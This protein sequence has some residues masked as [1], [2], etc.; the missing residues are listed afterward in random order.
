[1]ERFSQT[2]IESRFKTTFD[3]YLDLLKNDKVT[4]AE[5]A[6]VTAGEL[7]ERILNRYVEQG[8]DKGKRKDFSLYLI[9][10]RLIDSYFKGKMP[11]K[12]DIKENKNFYKE[13]DSVLKIPSVMKRKLDSKDHP[14]KIL[15][16]TENKMKS[17]DTAFFQ[18]DLFFLSHSI[19]KAEKRGNLTQRIDKEG[20]FFEEL[21]TNIT[22]RKFFF[23][24]KG[25]C[26]LK[27]DKNEDFRDITLILTGDHLYYME[28]SIKDSLNLI[29]LSEANAYENSEKS[30]SFEI[31]TN[32]RKYV[33]ACKSQHDKDNWVSAILSQ[34]EHTKWKH[35]IMDLESR[36]QQ[37]SKEASSSESKNPTRKQFLTYLA[38]M[39]EKY[40]TL[41]KETIKS[42]HSYKQSWVEIIEI[43]ELTNKGAF[44]TEED[45]E[46]LK[47]KVEEQA[48]DILGEIFTLLK[49]AKLS[50]SSEE[51]SDDEEPFLEEESK[52]ETNQGEISEDIAKLAESE[53][54][55]EATSRRRKHFATNKNL[56]NIK[57]EDISVNHNY[58]ISDFKSVPLNHQIL[59]LCPSR[60]FLVMNEKWAKMKENK[61]YDKYLFKALEDNVNLIYRANFEV[62]KS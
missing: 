27:E 44:I 7:V 57:I 26:S 56:D 54:S 31:R 32:G 33:I 10:S 38:Q 35:E 29:L 61:I 2:S 62:G 42:V 60:S 58:K 34:I 3:V 45:Q 11:K 22:D 12:D 16:R 36:I 15:Q 46:A 48:T 8:K 50:I 37:L 30:Y 51:K 43:L 28:K 9:N 20:E 53:N 14:V 47:S 24:R 25:L 1:M 52:D 19:N 55:T 49:K 21:L 23:H 13:L 39:D 5:H 4:F 41:L 17:K 40:G 18:W 59:L 6:S